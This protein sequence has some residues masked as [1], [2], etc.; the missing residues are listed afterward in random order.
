MRQTAT[1]RGAAARSRRLWR[2][3]TTFCFGFVNGFCLLA[4]CTNTGSPGEGG[5]EEVVATDSNAKLEQAQQVELEL[6]AEVEAPCSGIDS[7][8]LKIQ[9]VFDL[10]TST[11]TCKVQGGREGRGCGRHNQRQTINKQRQ[12]DRR[13]RKVAT[14]LAKYFKTHIRQLNRNQRRTRA[15]Y[16]H[17]KAI[18]DAAGQADVDGEQAVEREGERE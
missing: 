5:V 1:E 4:R 14:F 6:K 7:L 9:L 17:L 13:R 3:S 2:R 18:A 16:K 11:Q 10:H 8:S 12:T 15:G